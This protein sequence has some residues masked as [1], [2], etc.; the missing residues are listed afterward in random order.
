[1]APAPFFCNAEGGTGLNGPEAVAINSYGAFVLIHREDAAGK[2][3][4]HEPGDKADDDSNERVCAYEVLLRSG[5]QQYTT[6]VPCQAAPTA[7][8]K[9]GGARACT[10]GRTPGGLPIFSNLPGD[11]RASANSIEPEERI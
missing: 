5:P 6:D 1:V 7:R 4:N 10:R 2:A 11:Q 8:P 9:H 3:A